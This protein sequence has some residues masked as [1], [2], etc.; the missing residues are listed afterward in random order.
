MKPRELLRMEAELQRQ[1][2]RAEI[3]ALR[4]RPSHLIK[5]MSGTGLGALA[6]TRLLPRVL[7]RRAP[8]LVYGWVAVKAWKLFF[9][10]GG[11]RALRR[12]ARRV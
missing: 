7:G 1:T 11:R 3:D 5:E 10:G 9:P 8:W 2:L 12:G 6:L 4:R